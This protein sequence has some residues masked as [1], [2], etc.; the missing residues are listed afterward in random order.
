MYYILQVA[1][2]KHSSKVNLHVG[3]LS[4]GCGCGIFPKILVGKKR[5]AF[6]HAKRIGRNDLVN[7]FS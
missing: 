2:R 1:L 5:R 6:Y 7:L 4:K 3:S